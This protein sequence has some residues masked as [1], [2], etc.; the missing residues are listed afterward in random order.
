MTTSKLRESF[1]AGSFEITLNS[2]ESTRHISFQRLEKR[3][4]NDLYRTRL[5]RRRMIWLLSHPFPS[6]VTVSR[7]YLFLSLPVC[8]RSSL[9]TGEGGEVGE[10]EIIRGRESLVLYKSFNT[11]KV[12]VKVGWGLPYERQKLSSKAR[13]MSLPSVVYTYPLSVS[14]PKF[15]PAGDSNSSI[16][17][18][19]W[20]RFAQLAKGKKFRP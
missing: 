6:P 14:A 13:D 10:R 19:R 11:H 1:Y 4:L 17:V 18:C 3:M 5:S 16:P 9:P 12:R 20:F 2:W 15:C 8:R 7:L